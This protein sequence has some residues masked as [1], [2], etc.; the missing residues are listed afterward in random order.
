MSAIAPAQVDLLSA[1]QAVLNAGNTQMD[2]AYREA[3]A[4]LR[5]T[6][7]QLT[8]AICQGQA[9]GS[10][11]TIS[12]DLDLMDMGNAGEEG[13][14]SVAYLSLL[15]SSLVQQRC[16]CD[17][18]VTNLDNACAQVPGHEVGAMCHPDQCFEPDSR[19]IP[20]IQLVLDEAYATLSNKRLQQLYKAL[21]TQIARL[22]GVSTVT[23]QIIDVHPVIPSIA[24]RFE[25]NYQTMLRLTVQDLSEKDMEMVVS[26]INSG[27]LDLG[28]T[29]LATQGPGQVNAYYATF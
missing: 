1:S 18:S 21:E 5:A 19:D 3:E 14:C 13:L 10:P 12:R 25:T 16:V 2:S 20:V 28:V 24:A 23:V 9:S 29:V 22:L 26:A 7:S 11:V 4:N 15:P 27:E 6:V 8:V 17:Q